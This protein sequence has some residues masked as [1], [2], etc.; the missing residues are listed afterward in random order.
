MSE[1][2]RWASIAVVTMA[3]AGCGETKD[4]VKETKPATPEEKSALDQQH[5]EAQKGTS[6]PAEGATP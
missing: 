3:L 1:V 2:V 4:A 5:Q 6:T